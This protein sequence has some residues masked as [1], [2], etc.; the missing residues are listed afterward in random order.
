MSR[1]T[2]P[3]GGNIGGVTLATTT[4]GYSVEIN[5]TKYATIPVK[6]VDGATEE[7]YYLLALEGVAFADK[8]DV[9]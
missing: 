3:V 1:A 6:I 8:T 2:I 4:T 7:T 5:G 9:V